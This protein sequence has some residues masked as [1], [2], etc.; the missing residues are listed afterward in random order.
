MSKFFSGAWDPLG[1]GRRRKIKTIL[2]ERWKRDQRRPTFGA[3][4][5]ASFV[6]FWDEGIK[7]GCL[8]YSLSSLCVWLGLVRWCLS[9]VCL[10]LWK[11]FPFSH[12]HRLSERVRFGWTSSQMAKPNCLRLLP[13]G[14]QFI[15]ILSIE[16]PIPWTTFVLFSCAFVRCEL[17]AVLVHKWGPIMGAILFSHCVEQ[18]KSR[19]ESDCEV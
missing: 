6:S 15:L 8:S 9:I 14:L 3:V 4:F 1:R 17:W 16:T 2:Y 7:P 10:M 12:K 11:L 19:I 13:N 5:A 18:L